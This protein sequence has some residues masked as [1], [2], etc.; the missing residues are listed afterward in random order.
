V[1]NYFDDDLDDRFLEKLRDATAGN[2]YDLGWGEDWEHGHRFASKWLGL[3][4]DLDG[5]YEYEPSFQRT[6]D[7]STGS[8]KRKTSET[9]HHHRNVEAKNV[10][11]PDELLMHEKQIRIKCGYCKEHHF[12]STREA[13]HESIKNK[14]CKN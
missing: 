2:D 11:T 13:V 14:D 9:K 7:E 4:H 8:W 1:N 3:D 10:V 12:G 6:E 5:D